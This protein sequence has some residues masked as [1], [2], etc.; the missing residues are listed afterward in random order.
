VGRAQVGPGTRR[1]RPVWLL[2]PPAPRARIDAPRLRGA[3]SRRALPQRA[4]A[5]IL[6][7]MR[8]ALMTTGRPVA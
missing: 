3:G 2:L 7:R 5:P 8:A 4:R 1:R 6:V